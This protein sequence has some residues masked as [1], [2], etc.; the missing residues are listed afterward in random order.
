MQAPMAGGAAG[1]VTAAL[2]DQLIRAA[3]IEAERTIS[4][5]RIG[6]AVALVAVLIAAVGALPD[7]P[8]EAIKRQ[9]GIA[10]A[11]LVL[12]ALI[13]V[14]SLGLAR[15]E[16]F[17]AWH[18]WAFTAADCALVIFNLWSTALNL[19]AAGWTVWLFPAIWLIPLVLV[20]GTLRYQPAL[21]AAS[22][23]ALG[24]GVIDVLCL[25]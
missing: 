25:L 24:A 9:I 1:G 8:P 16:R 7:M 13:G 20:F 19:Q 11:V 18:P 14:T 22:L 3:E 5:I 10:L 23:A 6:V 15:P 12:Y 2:R 4:I 17:R 21:Q